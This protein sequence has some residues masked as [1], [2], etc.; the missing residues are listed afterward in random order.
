MIKLINFR[1]LLNFATVVVAMLAIAACSGEPAASPASDTAERAQTQASFPPVDTTFEYTAQE[2]LYADLYEKVVPSVVRIV[3]DAGEGSGFVWDDEGHLVT[4]YHLVGAGDAPRITFRNG[5]EYK[6]AVVGI[7][8]DSDIAVLKIDAPSSSL[9]PVAL[10]NSGALRPG[11]SAVAIGNP[12]GQ[13]FTMTVGIVSAVG[14]LID[15][16]FSHFAIPEVIQTDAAINPGNSGGPLF[17]SHGR[18]IGINS[19][20]RSESRQNSGVGFAVPIDLARR[21]VPSIIQTGEHRYSWLGIS[22]MDVGMDLRDAANLDS[23]LRGT[24]IQTVSPNGPAEN[25][26]LRAGQEQITVLGRPVNV[27]GDVIVSIDGNPVKAIEDVIAYLALN[28]S[29]GDTVTIGINRDG[30]P[31]DLQVE[32]GERPQ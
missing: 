9:V 24:L 27:G 21:V 26:G 7:D 14:R 22:A 2:A 29:P 6:A 17:D 8:H 5:D 25:A 15:S 13:D 19:Q 16:G 23:D 10:G 30:E 4:N 20:I 32:L 12:F 11:Q 28:T 18:A 1:S 31:I 3:S